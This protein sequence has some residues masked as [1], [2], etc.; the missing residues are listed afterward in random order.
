MRFDLQFLQPD[1][2]SKFNSNNN[3]KLTSANVVFDVVLFRESSANGHLLEPE[4]TI[5]T[6]SEQTLPTILIKFEAPLA[7][8]AEGS[9]SILIEDAVIAVVGTLL[10]LGRHHGRALGFGTL[11]AVVLLAEIHIIRV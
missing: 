5:F 3:I 6:L 4:F 11:C 7:L 9:A 8:V 1:W 10:T 2:Q